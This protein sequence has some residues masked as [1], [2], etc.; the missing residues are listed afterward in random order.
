M[1]WVDADRDRACV[2]TGQHQTLDHL[3]NVE[4][5]P[6]IARL[7]ELCSILAKKEASL[8]LHTK[9]NNVTVIFST[10]DAGIKQLEKKV[11]ERERERERERVPLLYCR[12]QIVERGTT[13]TLV[14]SKDET[15]LGALHLPGYNCVC[16]PPH[17]HTIG[18]GRF[19]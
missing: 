5:L 1:R 4:G 11:R 6:L 3:T 12:E 16:T 9:I 18:V 19:L 2:G 8:L 7:D 10:L 14:C 15:T 17:T 13:S